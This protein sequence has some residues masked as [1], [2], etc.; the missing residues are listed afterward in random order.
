MNTG[1][2]PRYLA[3]Q[4]DSLPAEPQGKPKY[5][6][7]YIEFNYTSH[8]KNDICLLYVCVYSKIVDCV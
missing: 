2:E 5:M 6:F 7:T 4:A 1:M 3:L 8:S